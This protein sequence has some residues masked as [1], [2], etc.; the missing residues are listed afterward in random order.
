MDSTNLYGHARTNAVMRLKTR[1]CSTE[2]AVRTRKKN[3]DSTWL[4]GT[5]RPDV[6]DGR[7]VLEPPAGHGDGGDSQSKAHQHH[8]YAVEHQAYDRAH[9]TCRALAVRTSKDAR[10]VSHHKT[11][12][13][14]HDS[15][16]CTNYG[17]SC[18]YTG[19]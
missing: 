11:D 3:G 14:K 12:D 19:Q 15:C 2:F 5:V 17:E 10:L 13:C 1:A 6:V 18:N 9:E 4:Y 7:K 8:A 16:H